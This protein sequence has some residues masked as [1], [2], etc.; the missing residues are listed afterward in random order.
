MLGH[1]LRRRSSIRTTLARRLVLAGALY[2]GT[3][4]QC[5]FFKLI[6]IDFI[7][8][9]R[10]LVQLPGQRLISEVCQLTTGSLWTTPSAS[11][12]DPCKGNRKNRFTILRTPFMVEH[13]KVER[14]N[15]LALW[16][17]SKCKPMVLHV[18]ILPVVRESWEVINILNVRWHIYE[19]AHWWRPSCKNSIK[20]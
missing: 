20:S 17:P 3:P 15:R 12:K 19:S 13:S 11:C 4:R 1:R 6:K 8:F 16:R 14:I 10:C 18:P 9:W 5:L 2:R 7:S